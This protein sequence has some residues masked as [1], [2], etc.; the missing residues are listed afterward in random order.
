M[1]GRFVV[2]TGATSGAHRALKGPSFGGW[3]FIALCVWPIK[4]VA[5]QGGAVVAVGRYHTCFG[6]VG[7]GR[8]WGGFNTVGNNFG[9]LGDGSTLGIGNAP[10]QMTTIGPIPFQPTLGQVVSVAA[11]FA[12][13]CALFSTGWVVCFGRNNKGNLGL[14]DSNNA[15]CGGTCLAMSTLS[16]IAFDTP[17]ITVTAITGGIQHTCALFINGRVRW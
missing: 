6:D 8:C 5:A 4:T 2:S 15:G 17:T 1:A 9:Q 13:S 16:G 3:A 7:Q 12:H 11:G 14:D 10:N